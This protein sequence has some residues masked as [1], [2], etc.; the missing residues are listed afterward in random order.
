MI[1]RRAFLNRRQVK[2][3]ARKMGHVLRG[4]RRMVRSSS[5]PFRETLYYVTWCE[6]CGASAYADADAGPVSLDG[7]PA[8][9][10]KCSK[11]ERE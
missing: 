5:L 4:F 1:S 8:T 7:G 2:I 3:R 10:S 9:L 6:K 11:S